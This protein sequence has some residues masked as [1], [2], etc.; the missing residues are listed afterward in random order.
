[1]WSTARSFNLRKILQNLQA[2]KISSGQI[3]SNDI[4]LLSEKYNFDP[5][6]LNKIVLIIYK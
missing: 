4:A 3:T 5:E 6:K 2:Y 1:M